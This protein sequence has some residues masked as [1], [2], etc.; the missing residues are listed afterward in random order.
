MQFVITTTDSVENLNEVAQAVMAEAQKQQLFW[1][2]DMDLK[3]DKPQARL[4][5]DREKI[6]HWA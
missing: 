6:A 5:V 3:L 4:V 2:A 1:F